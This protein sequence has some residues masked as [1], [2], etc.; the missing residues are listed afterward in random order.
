MVFR[1]AL[2]MLSLHCDFQ[3][4]LPGSA[5]HMCA[6][7]QLLLSLVP[8]FARVFGPL[9][10]A[11]R[12]KALSNIGHLTKAPHCCVTSGRA[13]RRSTAAIFY[14]APHFLAWTGGT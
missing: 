14:T 3:T 1:I 5:A 4:R 11:E 9:E 12:R 6:D 13:S 10:G 7:R 8:G 2:H